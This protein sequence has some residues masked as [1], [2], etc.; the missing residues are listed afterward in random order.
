MPAGPN[1][2]EFR[3]ASWFDDAVLARLA[4]HDVALVWGD[5]P[6]RGFQRLEPT[7]SFTYVRLHRGARGR[8]GNYSETELETWAER[9][10]AACRHGDVYAYCNNDQEGFAVRNARRLLALTG[11]EPMAARQ[12][13]RGRPDGRIGDRWSAGA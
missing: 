1:A 8:R 13:S 4:E 10:T 11:D 9:L 7:A 6:E 3:H 2:V 12:A 5:D